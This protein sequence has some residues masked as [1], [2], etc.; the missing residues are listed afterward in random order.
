MTWSR[1]PRIDAVE[2]LSLRPTQMTV[3]IREVEA[4]RRRWREHPNHKKAEFLGAH[5]IPVV[6]GPKDECYIIDHHHLVL[7]LHREGVERI[8][9]TVVAD[10]RRQSR[11][12]FWVFMDHRGWVHPYDREGERRRYDDIPKKITGM[13]DDP[14]RSLAGELRLAGGY[15]KDVTPF[16]EFL[17]ADF[18][19][20]R[21]KRK[22]IKRNFAA[23]LREARRLAKSDEA[24]Y[25]PG[26]CGPA[27]EA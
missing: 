25:L 16:N 1:E 8:V 14:Y 4:K 10:L 24:D 11:G 6:M 18:L 21:V 9:T 27:H 26:W 2:I 5:L 3:G 15:A 23:A 7:A 13:A 20:H 19:R 17:W 22:L 12:E